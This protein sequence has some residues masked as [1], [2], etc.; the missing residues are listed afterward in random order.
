MMLPCP[1][2]LAP[3]Q[4]TIATITA[5]QRAHGITDASLLNY[6]VSDGTTL[7]ATRFVN[8]PTHDAA[9]LYYAEGMEQ[10]NMVPCRWGGTV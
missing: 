2:T 6:C 1:H 10:C 3:C 9:S 8:P 4:A 5:I 7:V